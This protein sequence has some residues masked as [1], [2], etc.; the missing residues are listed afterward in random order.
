MADTGHSCEGTFPMN[1]EMP[2]LKGSVFDDFRRTSIY[3]GDSG[4]STRHVPS[5]GMSRCIIGIVIGD[6]K[7]SNSHEAKKG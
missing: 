5:R 3:D 1:K 6:S 2:C 7:L 4:S